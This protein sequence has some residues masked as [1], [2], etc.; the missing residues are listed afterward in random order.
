M[1]A[2]TRFG[3]AFTDLAWTGLHGSKSLLRGIDGPRVHVQAKG[4]PGRRNHDLPK[5]P[6]RGCRDRREES[7]NPAIPDRHVEEAVHP[8]EKN[9]KRIIDFRF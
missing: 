1:A 3:V 5:P 4:L 2:P 9:Q 8:K 7:R 6:P